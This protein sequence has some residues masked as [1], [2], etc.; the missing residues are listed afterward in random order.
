MNFFVVRFAVDYLVSPTQEQA[1]R[2]KVRTVGGEALIDVPQ[3]L[4]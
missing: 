2:A 1:A 4:R 3:W